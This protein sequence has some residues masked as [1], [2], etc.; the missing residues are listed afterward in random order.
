MNLYFPTS[1]FLFSFSDSQNKKVHCS[2]SQHFY[3]YMDW[4]SVPSSLTELFFVYLKLRKCISKI[5]KNTF[6]NS[7]CPSPYGAPN[8]IHHNTRFQS[9][10]KLNFHNGLPTFRKVKKSLSQKQKNFFAEHST[11]LSILW[12]C[13][14]QECFALNLLKHL[15]Y[16]KNLRPKIWALNAMKENDDK[17]VAQS[18]FLLQIDEF[19]WIM[20]CFVHIGMTGRIS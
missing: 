6:H 16:D 9:R 2:L 3:F 15:C 1:L 8:G 4:S 11:V 19:L 17:Y 5:E 7:F 18:I 12:P 10:K 13:G 14:T 20:T